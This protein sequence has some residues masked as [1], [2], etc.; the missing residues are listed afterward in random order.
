MLRAADAPTALRRRLRSESHGISLLKL[1]LEGRAWP[2]AAIF[3]AFDALLGDQ[4]G[5]AIELTHPPADPSI[6]VRQRL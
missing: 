5:V 6:Q 2:L 3:G 4:G 1:P